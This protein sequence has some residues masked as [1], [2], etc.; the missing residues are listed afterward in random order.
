MAATT[1]TVQQL[2]QSLPDIPPCGTR[3]YLRFDETMVKPPSDYRRQYDTYQEAA[4]RLKKIYIEFP[5]IGT[6]AIQIISEREQLDRTPVPYPLGKEVI[7]QSASIYFP[8][9]ADMLSMIQVMPAFPFVVDGDKTISIDRHIARHTALM[10][11]ALRAYSCPRYEVFQLRTRVAEFIHYQ[12][13]II[14]GKHFDVAAHQDCI[15]RLFTACIRVQT[16]ASTPLVF[17]VKNFIVHRFGHCAFPLMGTKPTLEYIP[18]PND[19][20]SY[21]AEVA[22][23]RAKYYGWLWGKADAQLRAVLQMASFKVAF[24]AWYF[25]Q[26]QTYRRTNTIV[27][28]DSLDDEHFVLNMKNCLKVHHTPDIIVRTVSDA[29]AIRYERQIRAAA[30]RTKRSRRANT[31]YSTEVW[32]L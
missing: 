26:Y 8:P 1:P 13:D 20:T 6:R 22:L 5:L 14:N 32:E 17:N 10:I 21:L 24:S 30:M 3:Y 19:N 15:D 25:M 23:A 2:L 7:N 29:M 11:C 31:R 28:K 12:I 27:Y 9:A 4:N 18:G 16:C